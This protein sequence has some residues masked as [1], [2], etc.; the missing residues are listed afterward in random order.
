MKQ[1]AKNIK[2]TINILDSIENS[3]INKP[4]FNAYQTG[5]GA[6]KPKSGKHISRARSKNNLRKVISDW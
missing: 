5:T 3:L 4:R 1:K 6:F 2:E